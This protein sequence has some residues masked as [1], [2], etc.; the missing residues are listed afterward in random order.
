MT[1][2]ESEEEQSM[3]KLKIVVI[4][5]GSAGFGPGT[6]A[7][8][9]APPEMKEFELTVVLVDIDEPALARMLKLANMIKEHHRSPARLEATPD[10]KAALKG[11]HYVITSVAQ[12]RWDLWEKDFYVPQAYGFP[13]VFGETAGPG[14]AFHTLRSLQLMIPICRDME[15]LCPEALLLNYTN[16]ESRVCLGVSKLTKIR[17]VGLC[18]GPKET[19]GKI[20][21]IL[22]KP[23]EEIELTVGGL[24]HFHLALEIKDK[25]SGKDLYPELRSRM[26][27]FDWGFDKLTPEYY[28]IFGYLLYP[29]PSHPG[30][31]LHFAQDLAGPQLLYWGIGGVSMKLS[32]RSSDLEYYTGGAPGRP[33]YSLW[34]AELAQRID[35]VLSG[36]APLTAKDALT[37]QS[38]ADPTWEIAVPIVLDI[39]FNSNRRE[40]SANVMNRGLAIENLP[41]DAIVEVPIQVNAKGVFPVKV[42][43]LP[44]AHAALCKVQ[45]A[46]QNLLVEAYR[47]NSKKLLLQALLIDPIVNNVARAEAMMEKMLQIESDYLPELK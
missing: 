4:G 33:S 34:S 26:R 43:A 10:R 42:G 44:E 47:E 41:E 36:E 30:E 6:I 14:A 24:N 15:T 9:L 37:R 17:N 13:Q 2:A 8:I 32:A 19:L 21:Q 22:Q 46:I 3:K 18:H 28:R 35:R 11:A 25:A 12:K 1:V 5:A 31:Y 20:S 40:I 38:F 7:D 29:D 27:S 39:E 23:A 45:V 16:P